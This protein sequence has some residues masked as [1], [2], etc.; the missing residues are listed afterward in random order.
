[1]PDYRN[2]INRQALNVLSKSP[3]IPDNRLMVGVAEDLTPQPIVV[4]ADYMPSNTAAL[5]PK[6]TDLKYEDIQNMLANGELTIDDFFQNVY[7]LGNPTE[8][9]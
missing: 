6:T 3:Q 7:P 2:I 5:L 8:R 1:M 4:F 9:I